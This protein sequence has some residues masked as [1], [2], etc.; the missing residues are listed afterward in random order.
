[1]GNPMRDI[2]EESKTQDDRGARM[3]AAISSLDEKKRGGLLTDTVL[4][5]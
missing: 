4:I 2:F 5:K 1:M 3:A